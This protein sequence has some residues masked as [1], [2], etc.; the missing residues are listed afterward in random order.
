MH[1]I[2]EQNA[3]PGASNKLLGRFADRICL[4]LPDVS[5][6]L[7]KLS[8]EIEELRRAVEAGKGVTEELGDVMFSAVNA[9]RFLSIDPEDALSSST[10]KFIRRFAGME[11]AALEQGL[12]LENM[13]LAEMD[14]IYNIQKE[15][16]KKQ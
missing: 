9:A 1:L 14:N 12:R 8:E 10:D 5:G 15:K 2:H 6:A 13:S 4:S 7:D 16:E 11:K 3:I